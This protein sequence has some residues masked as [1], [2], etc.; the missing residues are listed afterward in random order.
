MRVPDGVLSTALEVTGLVGLAVCAF[1]VSVLAGAAVLCALAV[2]T[3]VL[4]G[5]ST[6]L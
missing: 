1:T 2:L 6:R 3:G 4:L 5:R